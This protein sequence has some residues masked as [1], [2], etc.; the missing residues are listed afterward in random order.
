[1]NKYKKLCTYME[2]EDKYNYLLDIII[3]LG[4]FSNV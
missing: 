3:D 1:M 4:V 2:Y